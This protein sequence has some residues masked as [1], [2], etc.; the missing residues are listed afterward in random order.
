MTTKAE[1]EVLLLGLG[2]VGATLG[3]HR[4]A[5]EFF[6]NGEFDRVRGLY[7]LLE[8]EMWRKTTRKEKDKARGYNE[9]G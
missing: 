7:E 4:T 2:H 3:D 5:Q 8:D 9:H 1:A 6:D